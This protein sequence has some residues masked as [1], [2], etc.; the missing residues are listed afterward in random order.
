MKFSFFEHI[1]QCAYV[2]KGNLKV[3]SGSSIR[4]N[5]SHSHLYSFFFTFF[6]SS[7]CAPLFF[8]FFSFFPVYLKRLPRVVYSFLN[9][10]FKNLMSTTQQWTSNWAPAAA[11]AFLT[12][13]IWCA[14]MKVTMTDP[15]LLRP[16]LFV[17]LFLLFLNVSHV[18]L[19]C[20]FSTVQILL[21]DSYMCF[22]ILFMFL[23]VYWLNKLYIS[24]FVLNFFI[25]KAKNKQKK[26]FGSAPPEMIMNSTLFF[27]FVLFYQ[28]IYFTFR[29]V[30]NGLSLVTRHFS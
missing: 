23:F 17:F 19:F 4:T 9:I 24:C 7:P 20:L 29:P 21:H 18:F 30:S 16:F 28:P 15:N 11:S 22:L 3:K 27:P 12:A 13:N 6:S 26:M 2:T 14:K 1:L 10:P 5:Y 25:Q 8:F